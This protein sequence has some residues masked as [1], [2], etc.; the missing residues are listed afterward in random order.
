MRRTL[1]LD[2]AITRGSELRPQAFGGVYDA[3]GSDPFGAALDAVMGEDVPDDGAEHAY[4]R[5]LA[6]WFPELVDGRP[7]TC[8]ACGLESHDRDALI[9]VG[10]HLND[11][12][13]W[14]R[15]EF[16]AWLGHQA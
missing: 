16:A 14:T 15:E 11:D 7:R 6:M 4:L 12:H 8:P 1:T 13:R 2:E 9:V 5:V 10:V 3:G